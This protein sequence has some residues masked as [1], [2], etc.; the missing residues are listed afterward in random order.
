MSRIHIILQVCFTCMAQDETDASAPSRKYCV[1]CACGYK[2]WGLLTWEI[3]TRCEALRS[4]HGATV[5]T[6][7]DGATRILPVGEPAVVSDDTSVHPSPAWITGYG[8]ECEQRSIDSTVANQYAH[9]TVC[10]AACASAASLIASERSSAGF[11]STPTQKGS[12]SS[13]VFD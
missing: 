7:A 6:C 13:R 11:R 8:C 10:A 3:E 9:T 12:S 2:F 5:T 1:V 4:I